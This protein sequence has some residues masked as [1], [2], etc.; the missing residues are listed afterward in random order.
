MPLFCPLLTKTN[1]MRFLPILAFCSCVAI[2]G[3][4]AAAQNS[5][6]PLP[7]LKAPVTIQIDR[8]G[9]PHIEAQNEHDLF[10]AQGYQAAR[11]RLFQFELFRRMATGTLAE[12]LGPRELKRDI[13]ARLFRFRGSMEQEQQ[14]YH[15]RGKAIITAFVEGVNAC[16]QQVL[17]GTLPMPVELQA[18]GWQPGLWTPEVVVSRHGGL[19]NN[20]EDELRTAI[21]VRQMGDTALRAITR[22]EPR[23]PDLRLDSTIN[24]S[25][26][27][28]NII[29]P[30]RA[31]RAGV[32]FR[33]EDILPAYRASAGLPPAIE[34]ALA[35]RSLYEQTEGSNNWVLSGRL[36]ASGYPIMANDPHRVI[37][38][39]SL[40]YMVHLKAPG[41]NVIGGGEPILPGVSIGH[42][43][44]GA[45]GLTI[46]ETDAEDLYVYRLKPGDPGRYWHKG[47]WHSFQQLEE[48]IRVKGAAD[49]TVTLLYSVHGP[50]TYVDTIYSVAYAVRCAWLEVGGA[51]YLASLRMN[52]ARNWQE[53]REACRY[54]HIPAENMIWAD[55]AGNIGWQAV[56]IAPV[57]NTHSGLVPVPGDGRYEWAGYLPM[58][59]RPSAFNPN[60]GFIAT[61]NEN[62]TTL[63]Y[64]HLNS[65]GYTWAEPFR[66]QRIAEMLK[67]GRQFSMADMQ[68][69]QADY[70][71]IPARRLTGVLSKVSLSD[72][73]ARVASQ[74]LLAWDHRLDPNSVAAS[75]YVTWNRMLNES[76]LKARRLPPVQGTTPGLSTSIMLNWLEGAGRSDVWLSTQL[77]DSIMQHTLVATMQSLQSRLGTNPND[78]QYGQEKM[79]HVL[80]R[81]R[82]SGL[83]KPESGSALDHGPAPRGG[84]SHTVNATGA[85]LNQSAGA[86]F[87]VIVDCADWDRMVGT[88]TPGQSGDPRSPHYSDLFGPW[89]RNEYFPLYF[90]PEK[91]KTVTEQT[92]QLRPVS[93]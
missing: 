85:N 52:Q 49:T 66:Q 69:L 35:V 23:Q 34:Q 74:Y 33:K 9:V 68:A 92:L 80:I 75:I 89:S 30:Y 57:R 22:Y 19:L 90:S 7:G 77:R 56:G 15:P 87:R 71:S 63:S 3:L 46:F 27:H 39:P 42:N 55:R 88:N 26:L 8:W 6:P 25:L 5:L 48:T 38:A 60:E 45:W 16:I 37:A 73:L 11:D 84:Y 70:L 40:R 81:H 53:F 21:L 79:K 86:S 31:F 91:I 47:A 76:L 51:P 59:Q 82:L 62:S 83:L 10:F 2:T 67:G 50:V 4:P 1:N 17:D 78:W 43:D 44:Y 18:L 61:A 14:H 12:V 32:T 20:L 41:W 28:E 64:P 29:A 58:L 72:S 54:S 13:G 93:R 65:I 24:A 36:S